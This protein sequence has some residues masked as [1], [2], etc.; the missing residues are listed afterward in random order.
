MTID[1]LLAIELFLGEYRSGLSVIN[2]Y[3]VNY[4]YFYFDGKQSELLMPCLCSWVG[5]MTLKIRNKK[6]LLAITY[7]E[8]SHEKELSWHLLTNPNLKNKIK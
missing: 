2:P 4:F 5:S 6:S 8:S 1:K 3:K 7:R